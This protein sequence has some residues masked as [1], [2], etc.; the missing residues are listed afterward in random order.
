M[1][2]MD[3]KHFSRP[4][5]AQAT[6]LLADR[7]DGRRRR[8]RGRAT[9][10]V[11]SLVGSSTAV[12]SMPP[13]PRSP[14]TSSSCAPKRSRATS[15]SASAF[16]PRRERHLLGGAHRRGRAVPLRQA[17]PRHLQ[18]WRGRDQD[19]RPRR[20]RPGERAGERRLDRLRPAAWHEHADRNPAP[21][22]HGGR[23]VHHVVNVMGRVR[24]CTPDG[25]PGWRAC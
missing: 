11:P 24:S 23:A 20:R 22:R 14:P 8:D 17:A 25:V 19:G 9:A 10:A 13:P 18:R 4:A 1:L 5:E 7:G 21:R 12:A 2:R 3:T 6:R 16:T 15:R